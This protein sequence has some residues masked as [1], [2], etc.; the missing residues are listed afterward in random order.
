M[1]SIWIV[2]HGES[3]YQKL[4]EDLKWA[5]HKESNKEW[6]SAT[7]DDF[8]N[9]VTWIDDLK[10]WEKQIIDQ[11]ID[12]LLKQYKLDSKKIVIWSSPF[13]R[14]LQTSSY[15][16]DALSKRGVEVDKISVVDQIWEVKNFHRPIL[17]ACVHGGSVVIR[18]KERYLNK[19]ITNP[20]NQSISD[21]FF[22]WWYR[23]ISNEY[24]DRMWI[25]DEIYKIETYD[26]VTQRAAKDLRRVMKN[27]SDDTFLMIVWHQARTDHLIVEQEWYKDWW[28]KPAEILL[29]NDDGTYERIDTRTS[30]WWD[31]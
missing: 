14:T 21:Y 19:G 22:D 4:D 12:A 20:D 6:T 28:Q 27:I 10:L 31:Q 16:T 13:A 11:N 1:K 2:R 15:I 3:T 7:L 23:N 5:Y 18:W 26:E 8:K 17:N 9:L 25:T 29:Y 30:E 24:L